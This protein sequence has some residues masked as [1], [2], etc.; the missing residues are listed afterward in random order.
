MMGSPSLARWSGP[1]TI[2]G[3]A[4]LALQIVL[5]STLGPD[6]GT[7]NPYD[8]YN[9]LLYVVY[10]L[11]FNGALLLFAVGLVGLYN[12]R[13]QRS[14]RLGRTGLVLALAAGALVIVGIFA[15]LLISIWPGLSIPLVFF[16]HLLAI[17]CLIASLVISGLTTTREAA[18]QERSSSIQWQWALLILAAGLGA[19]LLSDALGIVMSVDI[20]GMKGSHLPHVLLTIPVAVWVARKV[21]T[22]P[23]LYGS[24]VGLVSGIINQVFGHA[25]NGTLTFS[26]AA[27]ILPLSIG[28]GCLGGIIAR[29]TM[30]EQETLYQASQAINAASNQQDIVNAI[31]EH[32]TDPQVSHVALWDDVS[33]AEDDTWTEISL[34]AVWMP[35]VAQVWGPGVWRPGLRLDATRVPALTSLRRQS[36]LL[37]RVRKLPAPDRVVWE[38]QGIRSV[39][40]LPLAAAK[41]ARGG[42]LMLASRSTYGFS[43]VKVRTYLTISAQI[44]LAL[45][46][47][48]L[49][50]QAQQTGVSRERQRLAG[51][52]HDT[53]A[54]SFTSI[55]MKLEA[56][57]ETLPPDLA[58]TQRYLDQ[59]RRIARESLAEARRLM[60]ALRPESLERSSL[61]EALARLA[62]RW[63][64]ECGAEASTTV[65]GTPHA[66]TPEIEVTLLRVAQEALNNC[67]KHAQAR[68]VVITLS[69]MNNLVALDVQDDGVGFDTNQPPRESSDHSKG[70]FG[71]VGMRKRVEQLRGTLLIESA[72]GEGSTVMVAVPMAAGKR[73]AGDTEAIKATLPR[74]ETL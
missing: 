74:R 43:R 23:V 10:N 58:P 31:G 69:Y 33:E 2:L 8:I 55:V 42:L 16:T 50:E 19:A 71:L 57:E 13:T 65:T 29:A 37:L 61:P 36:H 4:L 14:G 56:A 22:S 73:A 18:P 52:I 48:R 68:H 72:P 45:E 59:A 7:S 54:Q 66:L 1:A 5:S 39:I 3:A 30:A 35:W 53:L 62:E 34:G 28:A 6:Q 15:T 25:L 64:E 44:A 26:E 24:V 17:F 70:G 40:L 11:L 32:L 47:L 21:G 20:L 46:N 60:W 38:H 67:R 63:S 51:E 27:T 9:P 41:D 49:V 12:R